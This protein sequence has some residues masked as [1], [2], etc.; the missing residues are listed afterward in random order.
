MQGWM[1]G[2]KTKGGEGNKKE[3]K[4]REEDHEYVKGSREED[5]E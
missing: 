3:E 1:V 5:K 2:G 4:R